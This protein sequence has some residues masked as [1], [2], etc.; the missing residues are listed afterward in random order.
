[1]SGWVGGRQPCMAAPMA[2]DAMVLDRD[3]MPPS[4]EPARSFRV[5]ASHA[6]ARDPADERYDRA[7]MPFKRHTSSRWPAGRPA[8]RPPWSLRSDARRLRWKRSRAPSTRCAAWSSASPPRGPSRAHS[9]AC[10]PS[11]PTTA[12]L[13]P[14]VRSA[15]HVAKSARLARQSGHCPTIGDDDPVGTM[16]AGADAIAD[17]PRDFHGRSSRRWVGPDA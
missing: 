8:R 2:R 13:L 1:M 6:P 12:L 15:R 14:A 3:R 7:S 11:F 9:A 10:A 4:A 16:S 5:L 17:R